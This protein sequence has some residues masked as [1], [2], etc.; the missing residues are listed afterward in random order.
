MATNSASRAFNLSSVTLPLSQWKSFLPELID[1]K[2]VVLRN[3]QLSDQT[4]RERLDESHNKL[5]VAC[6]LNAEGYLFGAL[7]VLWPRVADFNN[8]HDMPIIVKTAAKIT[9]YLEI[10]ERD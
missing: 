7:I 1:D 4:L 10:A 5:A 9:G 8:E 6:P 2:C 3:D